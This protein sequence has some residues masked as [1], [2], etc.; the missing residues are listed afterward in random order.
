MNCSIPSHHVP[1][2]FGSL[3]W[4]EKNFMVVRESA[5]R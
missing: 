2:T 5:F 3:G 4:E 1:L